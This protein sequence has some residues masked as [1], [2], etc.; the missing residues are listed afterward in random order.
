MAS[1][2]ISWSPPNIRNLVLIPKGHNEFQP[3]FIKIWYSTP[4]INYVPRKLI[5]WWPSVWFLGY[6]RHQNNTIPSNIR[7]HQLLVAVDMPS[8]TDP[9]CD[10]GEGFTE[11]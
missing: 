3:K 1:H 11:E 9:D 4:E 6:A 10:S 2:L 5:I 8:D 7:N